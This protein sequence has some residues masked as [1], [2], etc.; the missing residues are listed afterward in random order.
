M[1]RMIKGVTKSTYDKESYIK[2]R[3]RGEVPWGI[4][5]AASLKDAIKEI[6]KK[7]RRPQVFTL[8]EL[9]EK[10]LEAEGYVYVNKEKVYKYVGKGNQ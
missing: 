6:A 8:V 4:W 2:R 10:G 7:N 5:L 1:E 3:E 9:L